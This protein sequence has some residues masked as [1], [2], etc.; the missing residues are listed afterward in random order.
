MLSIGLNAAA[1]RNAYLAAFHGAQALIF[2]RTGKVA[3]THR[4][5]QAEF[6]RF[7][8]A[9]E[10]LPTEL[11]AFLGRAYELKTVADYEVGFSTPVSAERAEEALRLS[12][13]LVDW[14]GAADAR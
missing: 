5:V 2:E 14:I 13:R 1:G 10:N 8:R 3:K 4:G 11:R 9:E 7:T 12:R 6:A